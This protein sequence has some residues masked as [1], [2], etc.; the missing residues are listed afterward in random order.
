MLRAVDLHAGQPAEHLAAV[1]RGGVRDLTGGRDVDTDLGQPRASGAPR[2]PAAARPSRRARG[3]GPGRRGPPA[4]RG[5]S[6]SAATGRSRPGRRPARRA[7]PG[8]RRAG[9]PRCRGPSPARRGGHR[10]PRPAPCPGSRA[11]ARPPGP[12]RGTRCR[13]SA[14]GT[15]PGRSRSAPPSR[16]ACGPSTVTTRAASSVACASKPG[17]STHAGRVSRATGTS[18]M[19]SI[20]ATRAAIEGWLSHRDCS[21]GGASSR[22]CGQLAVRAVT[23]CPKPPKKPCA[24]GA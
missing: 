16:A 21:A 9:R 6:T 8:G 13:R 14:G 3:R 10:R 4:R 5:R 24:V 18:G 1:G 12:P 11:A 19:R 2:S 23:S 15:A 7:A 22:I 17:I 20:A